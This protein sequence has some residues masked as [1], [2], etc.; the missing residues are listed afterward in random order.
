PQTERYDFLSVSGRFGTGRDGTPANG[1]CGAG[2]P[3]VHPSLILPARG[4]TRRFVPLRP[5]PGSLMN[6][7]RFSCAGPLSPREFL[8]WGSLALAGVGL[9]TLLG[10]GAA[11]HESGRTTPDTSVIFLWLPGGPSHL[12]TYDLKP[13][14][15]DEYRGDFKPIRTKVP[16]LDVCELLPLHA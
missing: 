14:A 3:L 1:E 12:E 7:Q 15:P 5:Q 11:A 6:T 13:D 2:L 10:R 8:P 4:G 16:G 9:S